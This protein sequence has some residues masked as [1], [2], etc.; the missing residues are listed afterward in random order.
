MF[1]E[2]AEEFEQR[3]AA[4]RKEITDKVANNPEYQA[5]KAKVL[6]AVQEDNVEEGL[7]GWQ[8]CALDRS[9][10]LAIS[11]ETD[12]FGWLVRIQ[13][14]PHLDERLKAC[15]RNCQGPRP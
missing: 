7:E 14:I 12:V 4:N 1:H 8:K 5:V 10:F 13:G 3:R 6:K 11:M 9:W 15:F 2:S